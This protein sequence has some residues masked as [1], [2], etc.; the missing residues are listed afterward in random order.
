MEEIRELSMRPNLHNPFDMKPQAGQQ[1]RDGRFREIVH[2]GRRVD[3]PPPTALDPRHQAPD[4]SGGE[5][6][7]P[8]GL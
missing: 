1:P 3:E 6:E 5:E 4:V 8:P 7:P 2:V